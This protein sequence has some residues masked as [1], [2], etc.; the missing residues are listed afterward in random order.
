LNFKFPVYRSGVL[1]FCC[2]HQIL[3]EIIHLNPANKNTL[4]GA[5]FYF[6]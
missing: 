6:R 2:H 3:V 4:N 1:I 5:F